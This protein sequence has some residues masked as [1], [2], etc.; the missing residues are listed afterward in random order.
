MNQ[1]V[2]TII[3]CLRICDNNENAQSMLYIILCCYGN[4]KEIYWVDDKLA[5]ASPFDI[6]NQ[7]EQE[8]QFCSFPQ[9][10]D[11]LAHAT[12]ARFLTIVEPILIL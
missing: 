6:S 4:H 8:M 1:W 2:V 5:L 3:G 7:Y 9:N 11:W 12:I 10:I